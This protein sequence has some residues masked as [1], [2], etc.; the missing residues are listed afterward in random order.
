MPKNDKNITRNDKYMT[1]K[2]SLES[3]DVAIQVEFLISI[4]P[5]FDN[6]M[7]KFQAEEPMIHLLFSNCEK[8]LK[9]AMGR[10]MKSEVYIDMN[11]KNLQ[12]VDVDDVGMQLEDEAFVT[13]QG[14]RVCA[15]ITALPEEKRKK[16]TLSMKC[17][18]K[19]IIKYL[20]KMLPMDDVLLEALRC[21]NPREQKSA[22]GLE[23]CLTIAKK[24]PSVTAAEAVRVGDEWLRYQEMDL[25]NEDMEVRVDHFWNKIFNKTDESGDKF[26]ILPKMVKCALA[27]CHSNADVERSLSVN[28]RMLTKQNVAMKDETVKGLRAI[29]DEIKHAGGITN[30]T[31]SLDMVKAA[32]NSRRIYY[33]YLSEEKKKKEEKEKDNEKGPEKRSDERKRKHEERV[34]EEKRLYEKLQEYREKEEAADQK[35]KKG[36]EKVKE[37]NAIAKDGF[38]ACDMMKIEE[39]QSSTDLGVK[40]QNEAEVELVKIRCEKEKIENEL[41][42]DKVKKQKVKK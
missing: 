19:T 17:F 36:L 9:V 10:L 38:K 41:F 3:K 40:W 42:K 26:I 13:M 6:F 14:P 5:I 23:Y 37:G 2:K 39:G 24:L 15:L 21:L 31:V 35:R 1:I 29:K 27:L 7:T 30:V 16:P 32:E 18:Y 20:Q 22:N 34:A 33:N 8:L 28:K 12:K 4:K 25:T 11:G